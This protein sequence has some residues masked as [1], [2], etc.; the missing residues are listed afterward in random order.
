LSF[1]APPEFAHINRKVM[2][3]NLSYLHVRTPGC[4]GDR[5]ESDIGT[6]TSFWVI[7]FRA[8]QLFVD[9]TNL[10]HSTRLISIGFRDDKVSIG[11]LWLFTYQS[12]TAEKVFSK[13][14][15][16]FSGYL[17]QYIIFYCGL[18]RIYSQSRFV[19]GLSAIKRAISWYDKGYSIWRNF[20]SNFHWK[21]IRPH[22]HFGFSIDQS[23][24]LGIL[25]K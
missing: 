9:Y 10:L 18:N 25:S 14:K 4:W 3:R 22:R 2:K 12:R 20:N 17:T 15:L 23:L 24:R 11:E 8:Q 5:C 19:I 6:A 13:E 7:V 1:C 21:T 16:H